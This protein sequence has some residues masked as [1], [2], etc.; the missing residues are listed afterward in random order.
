MIYDLS[1][2][3]SPALPV[4]PGDSPVTREVILDQTRGDSVTLS[5]LRTT[6]HV[7]SHADGSIHYDRRG[8]GVEAWPLDQFLGPCVVVDAPT[9]RGG[10]VGIQHLRGGLAAITQPRVLLRS[11]TFPD[12]SSW[13]EDF[14]GLDPALIDA[15]AA[16]GVRTIGVDCPSVDTQTSKD[17]PAHAA[18]FRAGI[19]IL[20]GLMLA[21]VPDG[22]Y[23]LIAL[24]LKIVGSDGGPVRAVLRTLDR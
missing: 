2:P 16:R 17:L 1:P 8:A 20:E 11:G 15:L 24:P 21:G 7:G 13:N 5:T 3:I 12:P 18:C 22:E 19:A 10:R 6:V 23:E 14:A 9:P 4:W